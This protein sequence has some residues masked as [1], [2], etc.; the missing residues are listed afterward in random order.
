MAGELAIDTRA[1]DLEPRRVPGVSGKLLRGDREGEHTTLL[2]LDAGACFPRHLH[3]SGEDLFVIEG[4][5]RIEGRWYETGSYIW[6]PPGAV[7]DVF[8]DT[9]AV[10]LI[11]MPG[12]ARILEG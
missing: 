7:H 6:T 1:L 11:H 9:G 12:P 8:S 4:R 3:P 2:R 5:I 10:M